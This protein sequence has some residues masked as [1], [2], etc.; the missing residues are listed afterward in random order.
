M[1]TPEERNPYQ[2]GTQEWSEWENEHSGEQQESTTRPAVGK[3]NGTMSANDNG[4]DGEKQGT[5][6][7]ASIPPS[8]PTVPAGQNNPAG[9]ATGGAGDQY[10]GNNLQDILD[11]LKQQREATKPESKEARAMRERMERTQGVV[12][13]ISDLGRAIANMYYTTQYAPNG[14]DE[15][16]S[17]TKAH[18]ERLAKARKEREA[19]SDRYLNY[20]LREK[21]LLDGE[22]SWKARQ[23]RYRKQDEQADK[24]LDLSQKEYERKVAKDEQSAL[25]ADFMRKWRQGNLD[26]KW[27]NLE[28]KKWAERNKQS[29]A[30]INHNL[31]SFE[32]RVEIVYDKYGKKVGTKK[33]RLVVNPKTGEVETKES[34][35]PGNTG[36]GAAGGSGTMPGVKSNGKGG[37]KGTMPGVS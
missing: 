2:V 33:T 18:Q 36:N 20:L 17:L 31:A 28:V 6:S 25:E 37:S 16:K 23:D 13:G 24:R 1:P 27:A 19:E 4:G 22:R 32:E 15:S 3:E 5:P 8:S 35:E 21:Q 12:N 29:R 9:D 34:Y 10:Q 7:P 11:Y 14:Y 26:V 30:D